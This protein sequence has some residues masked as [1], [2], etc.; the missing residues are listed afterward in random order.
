MVFRFDIFLFIPSTGI[1]MYYNLKSIIDEKDCMYLI[2]ERRGEIIRLN[3]PDK[4]TIKRCEKQRTFTLSSAFDSKRSFLGAYL[5]YRGK[6]FVWKYGTIHHEIKVIFNVKGIKRA[7]T[8]TT[9]KRYYPRKLTFLERPI[10][11]I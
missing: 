6:R 8:F 9:G 3:I 10:E 2:F 7:R 11:F 4:A 5:S 1:N